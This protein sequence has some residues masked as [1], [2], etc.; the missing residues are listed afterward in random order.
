MAALEQFSYPERGTACRGRPYVLVQDSTTAHTTPEN[1]ATIKMNCESCQFWPPNCPDLNPTEN[2][3]GMI[4][5]RFIWATI[6][7]QDEAVAQRAY[8]WYEIPTATINK[9]CSW[10]ADRAGMPERVQ[11]ETIEPLILANHKTVPDV[12]FPDRRQRVAPPPCTAEG[13]ICLLR[14]R[15]ESHQDTWM[16]L[17]KHFP[18]RTA[19]AIMSRSR[20][21]SVQKAVATRHAQKGRAG[22]Q[23]TGSRSAPKSPFPYHSDLTR[24]PSS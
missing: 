21:H 4:K 6:Q 18:G 14:I 8:A 15:N 20:I 13:D 2:T 16:N 10:T 23:A 19:L 5:R 12:Y 7:I 24:F 3:W 22:G 17:A 1:I 9:L 11:S